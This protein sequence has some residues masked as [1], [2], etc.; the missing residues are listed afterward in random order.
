[1]ASYDDWNRI[2]E[3]DE[4]ELEDTSVSAAAPHEAIRAGLEPV[5]SAMKAREMSYSSAST[6]RPLCWSCMTIRNTKT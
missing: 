4:D 1:M 6:A 3:D 5:P 2:D